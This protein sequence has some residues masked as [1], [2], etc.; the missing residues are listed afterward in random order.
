MLQL[1]LMI[2]SLSALATS[3]PQVG[4]YAR[5]IAHHQGKIYEMKKSLIDYD[6]SSDSFLQV[7]KVSVDEEIMS[8]SMNLLQSMWFYTPEK[9]NNV[10]KTCLRREGALGFT[11]ISFQ[12]VQTCTFYNEDA[13]LDYSIGMVPFGQVRFQEY[14]GQGQFLDFYLVDFN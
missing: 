5:Y 4:N 3:F 1:L 8:E 2:F 12:K 7:S 6:I 11:Q 10:L 13:Q 9:V 14:L